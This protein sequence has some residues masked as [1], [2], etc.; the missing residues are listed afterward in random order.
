MSCH[1]RCS[2]SEAIQAPTRLIEL[3]ESDIW[4]RNPGYMAI[5]PRYATLSHCWGNLT[6]FKLEEN[7]LASLYRDIPVERLC[8]TFRDATTVTRALGL[9]YI[10]IDSLCITQKEEKERHQEF[11]LMS[12][13]HGNST[14]NIAATAAKDNSFGL[15]PTEISPD[16]QESTFEHHQ[17]I[18]ISYRMETLT[19]EVLP[20]PRLQPCMGISRTIP[21]TP[22]NPFHC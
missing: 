10:W 2:N 11:A 13:V 17:E 7:N 4:L 15:F 12:G 14:V 8:K 5:F 22:H 9:N 16:Y 21:G 19:S 3:N 1:S 20:K 6:I 18:Y